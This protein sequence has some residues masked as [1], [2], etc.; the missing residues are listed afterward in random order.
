MIAE[1]LQW[2]T[3]LANKPNAFG[4]EKES[5]VRINCF[6]PMEILSKDSRAMRVMKEIGVTPSQHMRI[7][8]IN[9]N[10]NQINKKSRTGPR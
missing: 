3:A 10:G 5:F 7:V 1:P 6:I 2:V 8:V 4:E 9:A